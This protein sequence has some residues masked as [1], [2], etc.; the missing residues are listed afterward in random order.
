M[1][2]PLSLAF[3]FQPQIR[4]FRIAE[5]QRRRGRAAVVDEV[6]VAAILIAAIIDLLQV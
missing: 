4:P 6:L 1:P 5:P 2:G 3:R